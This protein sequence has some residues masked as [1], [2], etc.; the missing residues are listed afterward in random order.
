M[1]NDKDKKSDTLKNGNK[2]I[3]ITGKTDQQKS[4]LGKKSTEMP[5]ESDG[6]SKKFSR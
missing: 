3:P 4:D 6:K 5:K 1:N 2:K